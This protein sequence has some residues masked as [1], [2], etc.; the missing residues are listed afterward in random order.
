MGMELSA[1]CSSLAWSSLPYLTG[2]ASSFS[3]TISQDPRRTYQC[4]A[5]GTFQRSRLESGNALR[6]LHQNN[7]AQ[8]FVDGSPGGPDPGVRTDLGNANFPHSK[9]TF[10]EYFN[11]DVVAEP[12]LGARG[13][14]SPGIVR[15]PGAEQTGFCIRKEFSDGQACPS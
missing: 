6:V 3:P 4:S 2:I 11:T 15:G 14:V 10:A 7:P 8:D 1:E 5:T 12:A 9:R 13:D